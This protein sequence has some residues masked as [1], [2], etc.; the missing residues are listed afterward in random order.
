MNEGQLLL[1][2]HFTSLET[3]LEASELL[4]LRVCVDGVWGVSSQ[5]RAPWSP[6]GT[7]LDGAVLEPDC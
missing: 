4:T 7:R 2:P 3:G 6:L 5:K 1:T